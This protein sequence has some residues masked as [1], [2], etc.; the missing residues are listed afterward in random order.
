M[1][2]LVVC[3]RGSLLFNVCRYLRV[4]N[5]ALRSIPLFNSSFVRSVSKASCQVRDSVCSILLL[6]N[7]GLWTVGFA[8][9]GVCLAYEW[10]V[11]GFEKAD[12]G[13]P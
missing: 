1:K 6:V 11:E 8:L 9:S 7:P 12:V 5:V 10:F 3:D 2:L 13:I 4:C